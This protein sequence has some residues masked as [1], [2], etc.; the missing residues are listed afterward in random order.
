MEVGEAT[1][2]VTIT[3][4][5]NWK[6]YKSKNTY[7]TMNLYSKYHFDKVEKIRIVIS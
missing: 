3:L 7:Y 5:K 6:K 4:L 2:S 1:I